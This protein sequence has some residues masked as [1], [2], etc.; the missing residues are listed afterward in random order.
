MP[1]L[2]LTQITLHKTF[3]GI[4]CPACSG[5]LEAAGQQLGF[6]DRMLRRAKTGRPRYR[7]SDCR[8]RYVLTQ[9]AER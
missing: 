8:K 5:Q 3:A 9:T 6:W 1:L 7:C 4:R 2:D